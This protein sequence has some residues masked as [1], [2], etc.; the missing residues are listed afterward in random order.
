MYLLALFFLLGFLNFGLRKQREEEKMGIGMRFNVEEPQLH[1]VVGSCC[2]LWGRFADVTRLTEEFG[3]RLAGRGDAEN[4]VAL[5][6]THT[7][8]TFIT[9]PWLLE[10]NCISDGEI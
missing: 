10:K 7:H 2:S 3:S 4:T 5:L 8:L 6:I 9:S 1:V